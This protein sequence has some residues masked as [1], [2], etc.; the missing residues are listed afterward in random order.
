MFF[1][2]T[3]R[4]RRR[5]A[6]SQLLLVSTHDVAIAPGIAEWFLGRPSEAGGE[7]RAANSCW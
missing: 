2:E 5:A 3:K 6:R 4:G 7:P 1:G